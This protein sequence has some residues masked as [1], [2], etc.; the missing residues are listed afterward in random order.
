MLS[1]SRLTEIVVGALAFPSICGL[2]GEALRFVLP[3]SWVTQQSKTA[4]TG[5]LQTKWGRSIVGGCLMVVL[6]DAVRIYCRWK[7]AQAHKNRRVKNYDKKTS[8]VVEVGA[9]S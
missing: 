6:K 8:K 4:P 7:M 3:A 9:T 1:A 2:A 5:L